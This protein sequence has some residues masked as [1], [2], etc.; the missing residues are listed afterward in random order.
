M[1]MGDPLT[2]SASITR[3]NQAFVI[4]LSLSLSFVVLSNIN[5]ANADADAGI[6]LR[7]PRDARFENETFDLKA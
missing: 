5:S 4:S 3:Y 6:L 7:Y 1:R 2:N